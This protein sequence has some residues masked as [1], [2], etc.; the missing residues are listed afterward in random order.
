MQKIRGGQSVYLLSSAAPRAIECAQVIA[1]RLGL[2]AEFE[3]LPYLWTA[4]DVPEGTVRYCGVSCQHEKLLIIITERADRADYLV[5]VSH[6]GAAEDLAY[7]YAQSNNLPTDIFKREADKQMRLG[8]GQAVHI[9]LETRTSTLIKP[10]VPAPPR[11][12]VYF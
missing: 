12:A 11:K 5:I 1:E 3:Q 6:I 8:F 4:S 2:P 7:L 10:A 9:D